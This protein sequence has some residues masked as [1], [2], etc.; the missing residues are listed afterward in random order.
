MLI[1]KHRID[2]SAAK[3]PSTMA[4]LLKVAIDDAHKLDHAIYFPNHN[5]WHNPDES[6]Y[7]EVCLAG[8]VIAGRLQAPPSDRFSSLN[9]D[10]RTED[11]LD[12]LD[13]MRNG[14]WRHAFALIYDFIPPLHIDDYLR[15]IPEVANPSFHG[16]KQFD[17]HL[18]SLE[19]LL[20]ILGIIDRAASRNVRSLRLRTVAFPTTQ[21]A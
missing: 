11:L 16:W 7:C 3:L 1:A 5:E 2:G 17:A 15:E 8:C 20:T 10:E 19:R 13:N 18:K 21:D 4:G 12:A 9:F 14:R 6:H